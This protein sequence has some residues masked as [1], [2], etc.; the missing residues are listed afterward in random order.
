M[1]PQED[2]RGVSEG[3]KDGVIGEARMEEN[4]GQGTDG[5]YWL[6]VLEDRF[7]DIRKAFYSA[8]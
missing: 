2:D 7:P 8:V 6:V 1:D 4:Q 5:E 3:E